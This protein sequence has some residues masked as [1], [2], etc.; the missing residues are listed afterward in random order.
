MFQKMLAKIFNVSPEVIEFISDSRQN[1]KQRLIVLAPLT[2]WASFFAAISPLILKLIIDSL[3]NNW[4]S[5]AGIPLGSVVLVFTVIIIGLGVINLLDNIFNYFKQ[6]LLLKINQQ[7]ET[8]IEDKFMQFLTKFD[9]AFL[10]S[11]NNLRLIRNLQW[12]IQP[13]QTKMLQIGQD[14]VQTIVGVATLIFIIPL[15]HPLLI[16]LIVISVLADSVL[17]YFQNQ[18]WRSYE[19]L[20]SRQSSQKSEL[21]WR[22]IWHFNKLLENG[23]I[24]Q[25]LDSYRQR[26]GKWMKTAFAQKY[27]DQVFSLFINFSTSLLRVGTLF[28]AGWLFLN[29]QIEIGTLVVFEL[30]ITQ[31]KNQMQSFGNIFRNL[32]ELRFELFRYDFLIHIQPKLDYTI[33]EKPV[34]K[35]IDNLVISNL[36]FTYPKFYEEEQAYLQQ[37]KQRITGINDSENQSKILVHLKAV[38]ES[39]KLNKGNKNNFVSRQILLFKNWIKLVISNHS[40]N[41]SLRKNLVEELEELDKMFNGTQFQKTVL[42]S[43]NLNLEKGKIYGIVGENGA[44]KTT[45]MKLIK[46]SID[47]TSGDI[48]IS[49]QNLNEKYKLKNIDPLFWKKYIGNIDQNNF[50]WEALTVKENLF[51]GLEK[52]EI[53]KITDENIYAILKELELDK[54]IENLDLIIGENLE[55]SGGQ[56]QLLEIA[57]IA[58]QKKPIIIL[59]EATNQLDANKEELVVNLLQKLKQNSII[60]FITHRMTTT[61]KCDEII[62][63]ENG[64]VS[65]VSTPALLLKSKQANLFKTFWNKQISPNLNL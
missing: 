47:T 49:S 60:I 62:I 40:L 17:D 31:I 48:L 8:F 35:E 58:L 6:V 1:F 18:S 10:G 22:I 36:N 39:I 25:I 27:N 65:E 26:R 3:T 57:R 61:N 32:I 21:N 23:W 15:I 14:T 19:L 30:Y 7:T 64:V 53:E 42:N 13:T 63:L 50:L 33:S 46:R 56:K 5:F 28:I 59:D 38:K 20:E 34:F 51:L 43:I 52:D 44:G 9:G 4:T 37:M 54:K 11:E 2:A 45:L 29:G 12:N 16:I 55:L 41:I 24:G